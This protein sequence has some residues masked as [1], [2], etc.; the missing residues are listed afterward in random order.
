MRILLTTLHTPNCPACPPSPIPQAN[1]VGP[2]CGRDAW[3]RL[4]GDLSKVQLSLIQLSSELSS[5]KNGEVQVILGSQII[6]LQ[7]RIIAFVFDDGEH[8]CRLAVLVKAQ[9]ISKLNP[10]NHVS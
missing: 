1:A 5:P 7:S 6:F 10:I 8:L 9:G 2:Y 4:P 3:Q